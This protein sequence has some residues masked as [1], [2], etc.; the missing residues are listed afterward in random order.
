[1]AED[2][3]FFG[4]FFEDIVDG[5][6]PLKE[7]LRQLLI[8]QGFN[9]ALISFIFA[10]ILKNNQLKK[11]SPVPLHITR[12]NSGIICY[13]TALAKLDGADVFTTGVADWFWENE[14]PS[15]ACNFFTTDRLAEPAF[16]RGIGLIPRTGDGLIGDNQVTL[17]N[18]AY[19]PS[20]A[21][22]AAMS[23]PSQRN[24]FGFNI[25]H[26]ISEGK[27]V[28]G[29]IL[30]NGNSILFAPENIESQVDQQNHA[31]KFENN[32]ANRAAL[33]QIMKENNI[34]FL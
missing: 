34:N 28:R 2:D 12:K 31:I 27:I 4:L 7:S 1:M 16:V 24:Y 8:R 25:K 23:K 3:C 14:H 29:K 32:S 9:F 21:K 18:A 22:P 5:Y 11:H 19:I 33:D 17:P 6:F 30:K 10:P 26:T 20:G 15:K 13:F